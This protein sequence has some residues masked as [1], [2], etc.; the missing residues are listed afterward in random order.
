MDSRTNNDLAEYKDGPSLFAIRRDIEAELD[1]SPG[2]P[3]DQASRILALLEG[4]VG[5]RL[6]AVAVI[7]AALLGGALGA[8]ITKSLGG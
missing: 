1:R 5:A 8:I 3:V 2:F 7:A 4:R 6:N